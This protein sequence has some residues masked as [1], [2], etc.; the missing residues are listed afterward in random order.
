MPWHSMSRLCG[1]TLALQ[2][3]SFSHTAFNN[4]TWLTF[5]SIWILHL[6][7]LII[8]LCST[9]SQVKIALIHSPSI[10]RQQHNSNLL[11]RALASIK[12]TAECRG[13]GVFQHFESSFSKPLSDNNKIMCFL[14]KLLAAIVFIVG[15]LMNYRNWHAFVSGLV[16][17]ARMKARSQARTAF[18]QSPPSL[19]S[20][21]SHISAP[22]WHSRNL[23]FSFSKFLTKVSKL[24]YSSTA[25]QTIEKYLFFT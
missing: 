9:T 10:V 5:I 12:R 11:F 21:L 20:P 17:I 16:S 8:K 23:P 4:V 3:Q 19:S 15:P 2:L 7:S 25:A 14:A 1:H 18:H 22:S 6:A 13:R 24:N